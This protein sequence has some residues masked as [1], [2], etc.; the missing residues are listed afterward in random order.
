MIAPDLVLHY[1]SNHS[2]KPPTDF[3]EAVMDQRI[4]PTE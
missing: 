4:A 2:Y 1:V 3:I